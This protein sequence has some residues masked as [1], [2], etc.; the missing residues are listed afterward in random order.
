MG[1]LGRLSS[2]EPGKHQT[3]WCLSVAFRGILSTGAWKLGVQRSRA[4]V[5]Q[6]RLG[7]SN[8]ENKC[9]ESSASE[10]LAAKLWNNS[11]DQVENLGLPGYAG[12]L[13]DATA[14]RTSK[15]STA[16][17]KRLQVKQT[18]SP[19][20]SA[21]RVALGSLRLRPPC[22]SGHVKTTA[23]PR[24]VQTSLQQT[25]TIEAGLRLGKSLLPL[26]LQICNTKDSVIFCCRDACD[27]V[28][29]PEPTAASPAPSP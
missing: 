11:I 1:G 29:A 15:L 19:S 3:C 26:P 9:P 13:N 28:M 2:L 18:G 17:R 16:S 5:L 14:P 20:A 25:W 24:N 23:L 12:F 27:I 6:V 22:A 4:K 21:E 7:A 10:S 8:D